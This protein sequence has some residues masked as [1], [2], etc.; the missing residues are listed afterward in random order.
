L[1]RLYGPADIAKEVSQQGDFTNALKLPMSFE[2]AFILH[3]I[4]RL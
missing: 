1:I 2:F 3:M 4:N